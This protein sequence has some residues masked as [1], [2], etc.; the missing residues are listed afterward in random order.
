MIIYAAAKPIEEYDVTV[1]GHRVGL[2]SS[3]CHNP[4]LL[5]LIMLATPLPYD[6]EAEGVPDHAKRVEVHPIEALIES[7]Y[8]EI[9]GQPLGVILSTMNP[10]DAANLMRLADLSGLPLVAQTYQGIDIKFFYSL[11]GARAASWALNYRGGVSRAGNVITASF[12]GSRTAFQVSAEDI[13]LH[14]TLT[15]RGIG[16]G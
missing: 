6:Y 5:A 10:L 12:G 11:L 3:Y 1:L 9:A 16:N 4:Q 15:K 8:F 14:E 2:Y 7:L 13:Y